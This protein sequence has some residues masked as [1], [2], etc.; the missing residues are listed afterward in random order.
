MADRVNFWSDDGHSPIDCEEFIA[1]LVREKYKDGPD[2]APEENEAIRIDR[3]EVLRRFV[4]AACQAG[5]L[6]PRGR[7]FLPISNIPTRDTFDPFHDLFFERQSFLAFAEDTWLVGPI[8]DEAPEQAQRITIEDLTWMIAVQRA[9]QGI[10]HAHGL[11]ERDGLRRTIEIALHVRGWSP[12]GI[13]GVIPQIAEMA[14]AKQI[15]LHG[16]IE[17]DVPEA[18]EISASPAAWSLT[19]DDAQRVLASL[20]HSVRRYTVADAAD[21]LAKLAHPSDYIAEYA[22]KTSLIAR[23]EDA[24]QKDELVP[25][26]RRKDGEVL[27]NEYSIDEW[28]GREQIP[29]RLN[30]VTQTNIEQA[31]MEAAGRRR[32]DDVVVILA[33]ETGT[34]AARW[35]STLVAEI[36]GGALPLKNPRDPGDFLPYAVPKNLRTFYDR[37]DVADVNKLLD[38]RSGWRVTYRFPVEPPQALPK[39]PDSRLNDTGTDVADDAPGTKFV[40]GWRVAAEKQLDKLMVAHGG[41]YPGHKVALR[42]FKANDAEAA[43]VPDDKDD[44]FTWVKADGKRVTSTLKTFQNGMADILKSRRIPN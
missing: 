31:E 20:C 37:V 44:E 33:K 40:I 19:A 32:I 41:I 2:L 1:A 29:M 7:D 23:M 30:P 24:M 39:E 16:P 42:W 11:D 18:H 26:E 15:T 8:P 43:F 3:A 10:N 6:I 12:D 17:D 34:E 22:L 5:K 21:I 14:A 9:D 36:R 27:L 35:E 28:L 38:S 13:P 25:N 4:E